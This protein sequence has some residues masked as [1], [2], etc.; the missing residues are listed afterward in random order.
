[1]AVTESRIKALQ[2]QIR[3]LRAEN[4]RL[5]RQLGQAGRHATKR[6]SRI[7]SAKRIVKLGGLW[8]GTPEI[9]EQDIAEARRDMWGRLGDRD[10]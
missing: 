7:T 5:K 10:L 3:K 6:S 4:T 8:A 1:M 9:T 2:T